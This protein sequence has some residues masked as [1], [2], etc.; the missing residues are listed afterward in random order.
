MTKAAMVMTSSFFQLLVRKQGCQ[1]PVGMIR[2]WVALER[3]NINQPYAAKK[4]LD[5]W[6]TFASV[7]NTKCEEF[8]SP[9]PNIMGANLKAKV[10]GAVASYVG[11][12]LSDKSNK[13]G[14]YCD[15]NSETNYSD[16]MLWAKNI[17]EELED[18]EKV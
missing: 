15:E 12:Y 13:F 10:E 1:L 16:V 18:I 8:V 14:S 3:A 9:T 5:A 11:T 2:N 6:V 7:L 17:H 4:K